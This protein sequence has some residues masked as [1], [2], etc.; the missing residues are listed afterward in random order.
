[1][2]VLIACEESQT[3]AKEFRRHGHE[4]YSCDLQKCSG[5]HDEWHINGDAL[6]ML[7]LRWDLIVAH[8]PCTY[9]SNAGARWLY[10]GGVL[11]EERYKKGIEG[12]E[13]FMEFFNAK[14]EHI[15]I[16]NPI[17]SS[18]YKLPQYTQIIEPYM[19]GHDA[20]KKT[21]LWLKGLPPLKETNNIGRPEKTY[22]QKKDGTYRTNCWTMQ[23]HGSKNR[24][25]TFEGIAKAMADQWCEY[26]GNIL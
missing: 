13:F 6:Q 12:K 10:K 11:N 26:M 22:F 1:M 24:S 25:K 16:E 2:R 20:T 7:K 8:P 9:L 4:V 23:G 3:V 15:A 18:I 19:F 17:P 14:C 21:C 5:G